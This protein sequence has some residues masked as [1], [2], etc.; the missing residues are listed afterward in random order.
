MAYPGKIIVVASLCVFSVWALIPEATLACERCFGAGADSATVRAIGASMMVL[1]VLM[2]LM[3]G[4][5]FSFFRRAH[6]R[7]GKI[8]RRAHERA[9]KIEPDRIEANRIEADHV[10]ANRM[11]ADHVER[12]ASST[13]DNR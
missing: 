4:G 11:E 10:E 6:E 9:G 1:I 2:G 13:R 12:D 7:A 5:I 3:G 8:E